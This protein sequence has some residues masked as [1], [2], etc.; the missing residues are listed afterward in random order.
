M[1]NK[2]QQKQRDLI[3]LSSNKF[4]MFL[5]DG[6]RKVSAAGR[7]NKTGNI[8]FIWVTNYSNGKYRKVILSKTRIISYYKT[9]KV[10]VKMHEVYGVRQKMSV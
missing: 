7:D 8:V 2:F 4:V 5:K 6:R 3:I 9:N 10:E 1:L